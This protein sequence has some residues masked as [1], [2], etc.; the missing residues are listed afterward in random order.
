MSDVA[1]ETRHRKKTFS[2][3]KTI[4]EVNIVLWV[5]NCSELRSF[6]I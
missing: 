1:P 5:G 4:N 2:E 6:F 3:T